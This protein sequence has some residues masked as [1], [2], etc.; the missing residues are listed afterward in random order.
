MVV[1]VPQVF[2]EGRA[3]TPRRRM[4]QVR[5]FCDSLVEKL[6]DLF[7]CQ[8]R[9]SKFSSISEWRPQLLR[10]EKETHLTDVVLRC[11][12]ELLCCRDVLVVR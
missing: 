12:V 4:L 3:C 7:R 8:D 5:V 2:P 1:Q 6:K 9:R 10:Q 11:V